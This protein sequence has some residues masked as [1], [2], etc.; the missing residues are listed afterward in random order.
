MEALSAAVLLATPASV[1][2]AV[3]KD[4]AKRFL[5]I[6]LKDKDSYLSI[7]TWEKDRAYLL[8]KKVALKDGKYK[9]KDGQVAEIKDGRLARIAK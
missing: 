8:S 2:A 1:Y 7:D 3:R 6:G 5:W 9:L 4:A